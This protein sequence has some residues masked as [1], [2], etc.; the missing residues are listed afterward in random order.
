METSRKIPFAIGDHTLFF[1]FSQGQTF[2]KEYLR[3][4]RRQNAN[5]SPINFCI[6]YKSLD[7]FEA[8]CLCGYFCCQTYNS[9]SCSECSDAAGIILFQILKNFT[10][11]QIQE[12]CKG[13]KKKVNVNFSIKVIIKIFNTCRN[14]TNMHKLSNE[15]PIFSFLHSL[16][17][18]K[19][20]MESLGIS[21]FFFGLH[22]DEC[23]PI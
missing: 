9:V 3:E 2:Q 7:L 11:I 23:Y 1:F 15:D 8:I 10:M 20:A 18:E 12:N 19:K 16:F 6:F 22:K 13:D 21:L 14:K 17:Q 5:N 4:G